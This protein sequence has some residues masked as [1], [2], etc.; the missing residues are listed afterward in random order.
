M[1]KLI[2]CN[3][4]GLKRPGENS[5]IRQ[6]PKEIDDA[7]LVELERNNVLIAPKENSNVEFE[8]L[9]FVL[10]VAVG[11]YLN[12]LKLIAEEKH[13]ELVYRNGARNWYSSIGMLSYS[14]PT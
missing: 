6:A 1:K 14:H 11:E 13:P 9:Q 2:A 5:K 12:R 4:V 7:Y 10:Q 8:E 3:N